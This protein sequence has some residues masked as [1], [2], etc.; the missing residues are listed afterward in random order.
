MTKINFKAFFA[1]MI[2]AEALISPGKFAVQG[3]A[4]KANG[5]SGMVRIA[6]SNRFR[7]GFNGI[8]RL[9]YLDSC[10]ICTANPANSSWR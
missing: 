2:Y 7:P 5:Q 9:L 6:R 10:M 8:F 1:P 4:R 3:R